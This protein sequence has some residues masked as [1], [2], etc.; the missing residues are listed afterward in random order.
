MFSVFFFQREEKGKTIT[1]ILGFG[2]FG[3][4]NGGFVTG[5]C[6][7]KIGLLKPYFYSVFWVRAFWAKLSKKDSLLDKNKKLQM[8]AN[9]GS[10]LPGTLSKPSV[11]GSFLKSTTTAFSTF[12]IRGILTRS[13]SAIA[14]RTWGGPCS[15]CPQ[16]SGPTA[17][18]SLSR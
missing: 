11:R 5:N 14:Q 12:V 15:S 16:S 13:E 6:Y 18:P 17:R 9:L 8:S 2:F 10:T 4:K 1:G 3:S 7:S